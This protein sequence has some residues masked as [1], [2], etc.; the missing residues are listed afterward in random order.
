ML[1]STFTLNSGLVPDLNINDSASFYHLTN[2]VDLCRESNNV[3]FNSKLNLCHNTYYTSMFDDNDCS[4]NTTNLLH[5][6]CLLYNLPSPNTIRCRRVIRENDLVITEDEDCLLIDNGCDQTIINTNSFKINLHTNIFYKV[7]GAVNSMSASN[8]ELVND[9]VTCLVM[10]NGPNILIRLNQCLL[11]TDPSQ[12]ESLLQPHQARAFGVIIDDCA[13]CHLGK[14]GE[15]GGQCLQVDDTTIPLHFDG[16]KCYFRCRMPTSL[17]LQT[18][19]VYDITSPLPYN[20]QH[21]LMSRRI[22]K[23]PSGK[24][25]EWRARLGYPTFDCTKSTLNNTTQMVQTLQAESRE[26]LRDYYKTRV[27]SLKPHRI[28]DVCYSDTFFSSFTSIRGFKCFQLFA[29]KDSKFTKAKLMKRE[30]QAPEMYEDIIRQYGAPNKCVT[31]NAKVCKGKRWTS[32][33][34]WFCIE[35]GLSVPHHQHQNYAEGEGGNLKFRLLKLFHHTPHA[36]IQYWCYGLEFLDQVGC[37]LS[38]PSLNGRCSSE[39]VFG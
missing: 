36:P 16:W 37:Y 21:R 34:R 23:E 8:L 18:L 38:K 14:D 31:D 20:P 7:D 13:R 39:K 2:N 11:D 19:H 17:E 26:Y 27:W 1:E 22:H 35:T 33:N 15:P 6:R 3:Y 32:I 29:F 30:A 5:D 12:R 4:T 9:A 10:D 25:T 24:L 28:N